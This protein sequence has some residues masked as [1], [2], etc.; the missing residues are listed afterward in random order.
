MFKKILIAFDGSPQSYKAFEF[1]LNMSKLCPVAAPEITV[2]SVAQPP[3]PADIVEVDAIIDSATQH[4]E[5]LF[6][7]LREKAKER[8]L[9][10]KTEVVVGHP[11]DQ[12]VRYAK[13]K[14]CDMVI[15]GQRGKSKIKSWLLGSVSKRVST[16]SPCTVMIVK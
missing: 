16:Y 12:I 2:L 10:I 1:A 8:N 13:E 6:E 4:Y 7:K 11:A 15:V 9:E 3:E 14:N 5:G